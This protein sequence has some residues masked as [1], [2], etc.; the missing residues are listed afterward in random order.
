MTP[1]L[2]VEALGAIAG[3]CTTFAFLPQLVKIYRQGGRELSYAMLSF[4]F[5]ACACGW[6]TGSSCM[7]MP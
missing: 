3:S 5:S 2:C 1:P 6:R 7:S 4:I